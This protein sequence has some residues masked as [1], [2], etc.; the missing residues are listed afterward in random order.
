MIID[1][2]GIVVPDL[3]RALER[4]ETLFG[5]HQCSDIVRNTRQ[6][7]RVVFLSHSNSVTV[8]L[9]EPLS[10]DSPVSPVARKGGGLHHLCFRCSELE[11]EISRLQSHGAQLL[12]APQPGE[13]FRNHPIA[14]MLTGNN[15]NIELID[16]AEKQGLKA[17]DLA[18]LTQ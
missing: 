1:H 6:K 15:L 16:T 11:T 17:C 7:V 8:K 18:E 3:E 13:M 4:W 10:A 9:I 2:I 5:Y 14:F 12:V